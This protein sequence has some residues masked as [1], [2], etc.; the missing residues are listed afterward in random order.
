[1]EGKI[2]D[3]SKVWLDD[4]IGD[5]HRKANSR[6]IEFGKSHYEAVFISQVSADK[7]EKTVYRYEPKNCILWGYRNF[8]DAEKRGLR[9]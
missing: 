6:K 7:I 5:L 9:I 4:I 1:M 3:D 2:I 8:E